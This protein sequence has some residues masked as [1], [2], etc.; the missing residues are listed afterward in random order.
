MYDNYNYPPGADTPEAPWNQ[1]EIPNIEVM[2]DISVWLTKQSV[3]VQTNNYTS[4]EDG[5]DLLADCDELAEECQSQHYSI[6]EMLNELQMYINHELKGKVS[7]TRKYRLQDM[8]K[9]CTGWQTENI[10]IEDRYF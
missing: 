9:D 7:V 1:V 3:P 5:I 10:E 8:L 6:P 2:C 4:D